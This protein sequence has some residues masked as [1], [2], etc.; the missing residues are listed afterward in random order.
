VLALA[1]PGCGGQSAAAPE[2]STAKTIG[3]ADGTAGG[4]STSSQPSNAN[5]P[6]SG[7][8]AAKPAGAAAACSSQLGG[9]LAGLEHLRRSLAIGVS[10]EQY[11]SELGTLR[12][13]YERVPVGRLDLACVAGAASSAEQSFDGYLAAANTWG[14][15]V[16]EA[17][18]ETA[19]LEPQLQ[20]KWRAAAKRLAAAKRALAQ[21]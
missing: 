5:S 12:R 14:D 18:C 2:P 16:S 13:S 6:R 4:G 1:L 9:F 11:V 10:Y 3:S 8:A 7:P 21:G 20:R 15:C 19:E 17:G